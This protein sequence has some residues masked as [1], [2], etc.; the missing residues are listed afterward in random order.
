MEKFTVDN[1]HYGLG[2][3]IVLWSRDVTLQAT[4]GFDAASWLAFVNRP[5]EA[6]RAHA[7]VSRHSDILM[8][9]WMGTKRE[10]ERYGT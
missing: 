3:R 5:A 6:A 4:N 10:M 9:R 2:F 7:H 1:E 8:Y